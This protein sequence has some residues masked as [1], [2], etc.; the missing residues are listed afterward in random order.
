MPGYPAGPILFLLAAL[1]VVIG[2]IASNPGNAV[3]G[4]VLMA[5]GVPVFW[6][7]DRRKTEKAE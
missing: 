3:K 5:L 4:T 6:F 1:Y 2:S 7:W